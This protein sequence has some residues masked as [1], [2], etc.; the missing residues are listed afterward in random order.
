MLKE[1]DKVYL[2]QKNIKTTRLSNKLN[3]VKI[4]SFKI[5]RNI[6]ETSYELKLLKD[7]QWRHLVFYVSLL[8]TALKEVSILTQVL[9]NYLIK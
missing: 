2:L 6:K 1:G 3:H 8:K 5:I 7:M 9:D 4:R